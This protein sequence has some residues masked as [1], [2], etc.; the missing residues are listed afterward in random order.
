[1]LFFIKDFGF[2]FHF[3]VQTGVV[4]VDINPGGPAGTDKRLQV[5]DQILQINDIKFNAEMKGLQIHRI[6]KQC[7]PKVNTLRICWLID[8]NFFFNFQ[9]K[10]IVF[11]PDPAE[12][13]AIEVD[14]VKKSGK[15]LGLGFR[16]G[17]PKGVVI[18]DIVSMI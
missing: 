5:L 6:F 11:R 3:F 4:V 10:L 12:T 7:H 9:S 13:E 8:F 17:N 2:Y 1:L 16:V 15:M 14:L 18:S